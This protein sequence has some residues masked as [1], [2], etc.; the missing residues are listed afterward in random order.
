MRFTESVND[1]E[2][3]VSQTEECVFTRESEATE[4][5][6]CTRESTLKSTKSTL[7]ER[8]GVNL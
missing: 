4:E 6:V 8:L 5:C 7:N 1:G 3:R 2:E